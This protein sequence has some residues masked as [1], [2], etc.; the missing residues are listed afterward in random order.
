VPAAA[1]QFYSFLVLMMGHRS[2]WLN[3]EIIHEN[4]KRMTFLGG[5]QSILVIRLQS[6]TVCEG[7]QGP[8][9]QLKNLFLSLFQSAI[10][11]QTGHR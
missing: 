8:P 7:C 3:L 2:D 10:D 5:H 4:L 1:W 11:P 6:T 9:N